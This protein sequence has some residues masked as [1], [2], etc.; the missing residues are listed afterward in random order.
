MKN[1]WPNSVHCQIEAVLHRIR[2]FHVTKNDNPLGLRDFGIWKA[3]KYET[4]RFANFLCG[5]RVKASLLDSDQLPKDIADYLHETLDTYVKKGRSLQT[6]ETILSAL[7]K[8]EYAL[9]CYIGAY[10]PAN[11]RLHTEE[12]R[13]DFYV[14][15]RKLLRKSSR[16]FGSRAYPDPVR[17]IMAI[18]NA[19][20]RLQASLQY[21]GGLRAE[22]VGAPSHSKVKNPI[23]AQGLRGTCNDPVTNIIVGKV[24]TVEKGGKETDHYIS[25]ETYRTLQDFIQQYGKLESD[26]DDYVEAINQAARETDQ[27]WKGRGT[28]GLKYNFAQERYYE[29]VSCGFTHEQALQQTSKELSHNRLREALTYTRG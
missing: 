3:Y 27:Y 4:H 6:F 7:G 10:L 21:E 9:N 5:R 13:M 1:R 25:L 8:L 11:T 26:Y 17:L 24:A 12:M 15:A 29:C 22:G 16:T 2:A 14:K 19:T 18:P 23:T 28:H 20:Y